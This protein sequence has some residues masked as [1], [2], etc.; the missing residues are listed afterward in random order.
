ML[1]IGVRQQVPAVDS[2]VAEAQASHGVHAGGEVH[3]PWRH[4]EDVRAAGCVEHVRP[5][6]EARE[7]LAILAVA[8]DSAAGGRRNRARDAA[9]VAAPAPKREVQRQACHV[10]ASD[11]ESA[12]NHFCCLPSVAMSSRCSAAGRLR[13][14]SRHA[15]RELLP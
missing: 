12:R 15:R 10:N 14:R 5:L 1:P 6:E 9:H 13:G 4:L 11:Y 8:E 2:P 7:C 3:A